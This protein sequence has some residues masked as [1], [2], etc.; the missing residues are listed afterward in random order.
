[1]AKPHRMAVLTAAC[2]L[3]AVELW[4]YGSQWALTAAA[5]IIAVG[6]LVT[7]AT[8]AAAIARQLRAK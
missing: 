3:G 6:S 5:W 8:R 2:V 1:M 7:C 4:A